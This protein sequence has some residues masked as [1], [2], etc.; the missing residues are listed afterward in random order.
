MLSWYVLFRNVAALIKVCLNPCRHPRCLNERY[1]WIMVF[2]PFTV[3]I[4]CD[5]AASVRTINSCQRCC[6]KCHMHPCWPG[7]DLMVPLMKRK[8]WL[9]YFVRAV[10]IHILVSW[11]EI[12]TVLTFLNR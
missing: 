9:L 7:S 2:K 1:V 3:S 12:V 10:L 11:C 8:A 6:I 4:S 5:V